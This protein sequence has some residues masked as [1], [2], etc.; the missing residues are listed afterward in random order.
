MG[1]RTDGAD[2][3]Q[4]WMGDREAAGSSYRYLTSGRALENFTDYNVDHLM[5]LFAI[6]DMEYHLERTPELDDPSLA[7][8][9]EKAIAML[10]SKLGG[11]HVFIEVIDETLEL[12]AAVTKALEMVDLE[13]TLIFVTADHSLAMTDS[14]S[15]NNTLVKI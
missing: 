9:T 7:L 3:I 6:E 1:F 14:L 8:M 11:F 12:D 5:G 2:L 10:S 15:T 4:E 13:E